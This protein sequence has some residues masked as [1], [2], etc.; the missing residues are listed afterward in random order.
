M[1]IT[2]GM[3]S[4][5]TYA[6]ADFGNQHK[7]FKT[8]GYVKD[9]GSELEVVQSTPAAMTV[10][11]GSGRAWIQGY[12]YNNSAAKTIT[13]AAADPVYG[14]IDR[15]VLRLTPTAAPRQIVVAVL[16][17]VASSS[18][19]A[20]A[21]TQDA[22]TYEILLAEVTVEAA[23]TQILTADI[24]DKR[25]DYTVCGVSSC[26]STNFSCL[27]T[28]ANVDMGGMKLTN[29]P[30]PSAATDIARKAYYDSVVGSALGKNKCEVVPV[31]GAI[32]SGWLECNG[33]SLLRASYPD[34]F[35][36]FGTTFGSADGTHFNLPDLR[37]RMV[38]GAD[39]TIGTTGGANTVTLAEATTPAH[40]HTG[41]APGT[42]LSPGAFMTYGSGST[43]YGGTS[44]TDYAATAGSGTSHANLPP[45]MALR[46]MVRAS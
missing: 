3:Y 33:A 24:T 23:E 12:W 5:G 4:S 15:I 10:S 9:S 40:T 20:T 41:C 8:D 19:T 27:I 34:L 25:D 46:F 6:H 37:G 14:R 42:A 18:P 45:Y 13:L 29:L 39:A 30:A 17:G 22:T 1:A 28:T 16:T 38:Y 35:T 43:W 32:P 2:S 7:S 26:K 36:A 44:T 21:L 31:Y 11:L